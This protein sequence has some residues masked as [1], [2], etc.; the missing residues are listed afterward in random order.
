MKNK[1]IVKK[2]MLILGA[3]SLLTIGLY[4]FS[5]V[6]SN[7]NAVATDPV[8]TRS[9]SNGGCVEITSI[10]G[11]NKKVTVKWHN[12]GGTTNAPKYKT[13]HVL[14]K[15]FSGTDDHGTYYYFLHNGSSHK[16]LID[17][18]IFYPNE[19]VSVDDDAEFTNAMFDKNYNKI[20]SKGLQKIVNEK[21][22]V[23]VKNFNYVYGHTKLNNSNINYTISINDAHDDEYN[24]IKMVTV[25][26]KI[27][28]HLN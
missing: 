11:K 9:I 20:K 13:S 22:D 26:K 18:D 15:I 5:S 17:F 8:C 25:K 14:G 1:N 24:T 10:V 2:I 21:E 19:D 3:F 16:Y 12:M 7:M 23:F 28:I 4:V 6:N 27:A